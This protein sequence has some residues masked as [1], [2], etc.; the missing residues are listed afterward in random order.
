MWKT[1]LSLSTEKITCFAYIL[2]CNIVD[3]GNQPISF[4]IVKAEPAE[5][6][7]PFAGQIPGAGAF[8][9][10]SVRSSSQPHSSMQTLR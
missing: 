8:N 7:S 4:N 2:L 5:R 1:R 3:A 6:I 9:L 10:Q